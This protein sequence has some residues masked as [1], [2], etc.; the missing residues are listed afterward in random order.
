MSSFCF[1]TQLIISATIQRNVLGLVLSKYLHIYTLQQGPCKRGQRF[2]YDTD[3]LE[4]TCVSLLEAGLARPRR[5]FMYQ[6]MSFPATQ[7]RQY[8]HYQV[9]HLSACIIQV[10]CL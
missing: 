2:G 7:D 5:S 10:L 4:A 3:K 1:D 6:Q 9:I 8:H